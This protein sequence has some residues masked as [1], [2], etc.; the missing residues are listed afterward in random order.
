VLGDNENAI[1]VDLCSPKD[2][3]NLTGGAWKLNDRP[4]IEMRQQ[5]P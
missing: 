4:A 2:L 5:E 3:G 1:L